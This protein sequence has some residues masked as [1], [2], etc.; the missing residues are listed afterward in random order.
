MRLA[1]VVPAHDEAAELPGLLA[2]LAAQTDRDFTLVVVD[3]AST[4]DTAAIAAAA[5]A[6]VV[7]EPAMGAGTAADTGF[8]HA[9]ALGATGLLRTDADCRP[10]PDWVATARGL[11]AGGAEFVC[12]RSVPR[13]DERPSALERHAYPA[14]VRLAALAGR[15]I[16]R[17][18]AALH[19]YV[20][21]HG[22]NIALTADLYVRCGGAP[23]ERLEDGAEDVTLLNR[24][25]RHTAAIR[26]A[27]HLV[28][29]SSLRRLR[30][31]GARRTL[32]WHW[33]RRWRPATAAQVHVR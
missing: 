31:W 18:P 19:P 20:L 9:I 29:E 13:R 7:A 12:G 3:N 16:Q 30:A 6:R 23:R 22:H 14:A 32:L 8:R 10:R 1:V 28:V 21:V 26:R 11:L 24:A 27:E 2:A 4:D 33:D 15:W 17:D 25:R 5:G